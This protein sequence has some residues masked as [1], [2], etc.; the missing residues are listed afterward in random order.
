MLQSPHANAPG[1]GSMLS[2]ADAQTV[3]LRYARPL[4]P[5]EI[6]LTPAALG[7]VLAEDIVCDRDM[8]PFD[9][10]LMDG[11]AVRAADLSDGRATLT[12]TEEI[13]AGRTP[14]K[15]VGSNQAAR[16]MTGA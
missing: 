5:Q 12:I 1:D 9:K 10:A 3:V 14:E 6:T 11:Y 16:I 15:S 7:L 8:P 4:P 2:V 13:T